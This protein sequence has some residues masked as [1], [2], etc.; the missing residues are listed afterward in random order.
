ML[1]VNKIIKL[2]FVAV[3]LLI[4]VVVLLSILSCCAMPVTEV[5]GKQATGALKDCVNNLK[6]PHKTRLVTWNAGSA[7][8]SR[9]IAESL[10]NLISEDQLCILRGDFA[11]DSRFDSKGKEGEFLEYVGAAPIETKLLVLCDYFETLQETADEYGYAWAS[12]IGEC[13]CVHGSSDGVNDRCCIVA[14]VHS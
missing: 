4:A 11:P 8:S 9:S 5:P 3:L 6:Q 2:V 13:K 10:A 12:Q 7:L 1:W 14:I